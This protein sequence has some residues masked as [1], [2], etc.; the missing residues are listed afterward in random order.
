MKKGDLVHHKLLGYCLLKDVYLER[1]TI[2]KLK[3]ESVHFQPVEINH[4]RLVK[5]KEKE[6]VF[7]QYT[8]QWQT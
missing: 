6:E 8:I 5:W 3:R 7:N 4:L 1:A 2:Y